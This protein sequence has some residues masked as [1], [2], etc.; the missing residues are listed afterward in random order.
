MAVVD[1]AMTAAGGCL[2]LR[3]PP[4]VAMRQ[5]YA[6]PAAA[7]G[8]AWHPACLPSACPASAPPPAAASP[9]STDCQA[10]ETTGQQRERV[11]RAAVA[12]AETV[13][14]VVVAADWDAAE[15]DEKVHVIGA[16]GVAEQ[17]A[18]A[19]CTEEWVLATM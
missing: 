3:L 5:A 12:A 2:L 19:V 16:L 18:V 8:F 9:L 15:D 14:A 10:A 1:T 6:V 4:S 7:A 13:A 11:V 17:G